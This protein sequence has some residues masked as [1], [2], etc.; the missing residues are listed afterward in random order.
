MSEE[1]TP[2]NDG[3]AGNGLALPP[4]EEHTM[5]LRSLSGN[6]QRT[7]DYLARAGD[8][9]SQL[10]EQFELIDHRFKALTE[11]LHTIAAA[12]A[13]VDSDEPP[14]DATLAQA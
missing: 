2:Y 5:S 11:A 3:S 4:M 1:R 9:I 12:P 13:M 7:G 8:H 6:V 10:K 14:P